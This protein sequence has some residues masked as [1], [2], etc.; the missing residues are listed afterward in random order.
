MGNPRRQVSLVRRVAESSNASY[1]VV[2][3]ATSASRTFV[4]ALEVATPGPS[5]AEER[6]TRVLE[7][8]LSC[9]TPVMRWRLLVIVSTVS[10][11]SSCAL[12]GGDGT[13]LGRDGTGRVLTGTVLDAT[14]AALAGREL[15]V[16]GETPWGAIMACPANDGTVV[17][18]FDFVSTGAQAGKRTEAELTAAV[19]NH[20]TQLH[21]ERLPQR[22]H[23]FAVPEEDVPFSSDVV[24]AAWTPGVT[25]PV[26]AFF[27]VSGSRVGSS[28]GCSSWFSDLN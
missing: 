14:D 11:A 18:I 6:G 7:I 10:L 22:L 16:A 13:G 21:G 2:V 26:A 20:L 3:V 9:H 4:R 5:R 25:E 12:F 27:T 19:E 17:Q 8:G 28:R 15:T 23:L 24:A 1:A